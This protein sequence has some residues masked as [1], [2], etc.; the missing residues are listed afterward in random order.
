MGQQ[1]TTPLSL[2]LDHWKEVKSRA[3][4]QSMEIK[5]NR[6]ITFCSSEWPMF[7]VG[8]PRD[9]T[10][11][12]DVILQVKAKIFS[13]G[14]MGHPDQVAYIV[15][16]ESLS[17]EPPSWVT[18]FLSPARRTP[19]PSAPPSD[20]PATTSLY[21]V[22][23]RQKPVLP[24]D[25]NGPADLLNENPPPYHPPPQAAMA[26]PEDVQA[27]GPEAAP[28]PIAGRL[29]ER[30]GQGDSSHILPL[31]LVGGEGNQHQY[32]PFSASD[33][34]NWK[35]HN[36]SFSQDPQALTAL[37]ESILLTHQPTWDDCQQLLQVLL[38]TEEKQ[39]VILEAR[40]HVPGADGRPT[41][42]PNEIEAA[43][44]LTRPAWD[45]NTAEGRGHLRLYRQVLVAGLQ[46]AG[47]RPTN[48]A[49]VRSVMQGT[50][51]PPTVFLERLKEA[52]RRYTPFDPD[53]PD[54]EVSVSMSF[55]WQSAPDIR[56]KLQR[57]ENLQG[58][59]LRD[60]LREAERIFNK[61]ETPEEKEERQR[62]EAEDRETVRDK[63]RN[64][65]LSR[66]LATVVRKEDESRVERKGD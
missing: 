4:N 38:T 63:R 8:W 36:P 57:M 14:S 46:G 9:G 17:L 31:R 50:D 43:F 27:E 64:K 48:L 45:F 2:T 60:L 58:Q 24:P 18:P 28:S 59:G 6:W 49:K 20:P 25:E 23:V 26:V 15:T 16:W 1:L 51:E 66:I 34:Y 41:Q 44:P 19:L 40:K 5:K 7:N 52:Y 47:R 30:R 61:R 55:I 37:I 33:L 12:S 3:H 53:S 11:D 65:E 56:S 39:R 22:V 10:F 21:P 35:T 32:W 13:P 42:L 29:R 62:R 54:Q